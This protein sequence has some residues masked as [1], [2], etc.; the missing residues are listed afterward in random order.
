MN[1]FYESYKN[2]FRKYATFSGRADRQEYAVFTVVN[3]ILSLI[4][5]LIPILG[6]LFG[7]IIIIPGIAVAVRRLH[8]LNRSGWL[9]LVPYALL[10]LGFIVLASGSGG[11]NSV[12]FMLMLLGGLAIL[13]MAIWMIFFKG[14]AGTNRFGDK[15]NYNKDETMPNNYRSAD[16]VTARLE[17]AKKMRDDGLVSESEYE[18]MRTKIIKDI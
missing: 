18:V 14:T 3:F 7:L 11:E 2:C 15:Q 6:A 16:A 4:L 5:G 13:V 12:A 8:D 10:V 1:T 17:Q 9:L